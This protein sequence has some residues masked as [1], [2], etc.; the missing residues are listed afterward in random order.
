[1]KKLIS[2]A[3]LLVAAAVSAQGTY[4]LT[5]SQDDFSIVN[6][7]GMLGIVCADKQMFLLEETNMPALP[8]KT[9]NVLCSQNGEVSYDISFVKTLI[10]SDVEMKGNPAPYPTSMIEE[11]T[12]SEEEAASVNSVTSPVI[13]SGLNVMMG[14]PLCSFNVTPFLYD[15][16]SG[17]L[18]FVPEITI[19][20][21]LDFES[22]TVGDSNDVLREDVQ[23]YIKSIVINPED[24]SKVRKLAPKVSSNTEKQNVEYLIVTSEA[25][26]DGFIQLADWKNRKGVRTEV[27]T[28]E[29]IYASYQGTTQQ[30]KIKN[31]LYEYY[32]DRG[33]KWVLLGGDVDIIPKQ[34]CYVKQGK[35][36][37][38][39]DAPADLFYACF[40]NQFDWDADGDGIIGELE[41]NVDLSAEIYVGRLPVNSTSQV[42]DFSN[43]LLRY[44]L[45]PKEVGYLGRMLLSGVELWNTWDGK[46]DAQWRSEYMYENHIKPY[47][48]GN[49]MGLYDTGNTFGD[50]RTLTRDN[51]RDELDSGYHFMHIMTHGGK[52][53]WS[54]DGV[55]YAVAQAQGQ[56]NRD[57]TIIVTTACNTNWFDGTTDPCLS[58]SFIRNSH[59]ACLAYLGSSRYGWGF[60]S[61]TVTLGSS[62]KYDAAFFE[63]LF[64]GRF[65]NSLGEALASAKQDYVPSS[66]SYNSTRWLQFTLNLIGDPEMP[67]YTDN[68]QRFAK[69]MVTVSGDDIVVSTGGVQ[70]CRICLMSRDGGASYYQVVD[71]VSSY[72]F[73]D[74]GVPF[75]V[76]ITKRNY[77]PYL[78]PETDS[79][80][81]NVTYTENAAINGEEI[82]VGNDVTPYKES[83]DVVIESGAKVLM[84]ASGCVTIKNGFECKSGGLFEIK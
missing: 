70:D 14:Y 57:A 38:Y 81:Q 21:N 83:G 31:C 72:T 20:I 80:I 41:D 16:A 24:V 26:S 62:D 42:I 64:S 65:E 35:N 25:L 27:L 39:N 54:M 71:G 23:D 61:E 49:V 69:P 77:A 30:L 5:F 78:Y 28:V 53:T 84:D 36:Y 47:W 19:T 43:K 58:E 34:G 76:T 45:F 59:G 68:V 67:V 1:M 74:V 50:S 66:K 33:L 73:K 12:V 18:F 10:C 22:P 17:E 82:Y 52:T 32:N 55:S 56:E 63:Y 9:V 15:A 60:S 11:Q 13:Y 40:D 6:E 29:E 8:Y 48:D 51:L 4:K 37:V 46:S 75:Y 79:Y 3:V 7:G 2:L 44:E